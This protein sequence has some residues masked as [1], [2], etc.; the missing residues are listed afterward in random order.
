V[1]YG[2][3]KIGF[4]VLFLAVVNVLHAQFY[5]GHQ[6]T[7]GKNRVQYRNY[8]W[9]HYI[10]D[11]YKVYFSVGGDYTARYVGLNAS[12]I[13]TEM[14]YRLDYQLDGE[15]NFIVYND[16]LDFRQSNIGLVSG[17]DQYNIGGV[18]SISN[19]KVMI[20]HYG[21]HHHIDKQIR[22]AIAELLINEILVGNRFSDRLTNTA[23]I[24]YPEWY[25]KGLIAYYGNEFDAN[26]QQKIK[27]GLQ[28][29]KYRKLQWLTDED[30][31]LAGL[32]F[33]T[34]IAINYGEPALRD[35][36]YL[37]RITKNINNAFVFVT[38]VPFRYLIKEWAA[39]YKYRYEQDNAETEE[40]SAEAIDVRVKKK[41]LYQNLKISPDKQYIAWNTNEN[42]RVSIY[43]QNLKTGKKERIYKFGNSLPQ[44]VDVKYP[45]MQWFANSQMLTWIFEKEQIIKL[46]FY[47][48]E[49]K[50]LEFRNIAH[51]NRI[52]DYDFNSDGSYMVFSGIKNGKT[53]LF[54]L[55]L[56]SNSQTQLT[57]D[58]P[59]DLYPKFTSNDNIIFSSNRSSSSQNKIDDNYDVFR[60]PF[61]QFEPVSIVDS[62]GDQSQMIPLKKDEFLYLTDENGIRNRFYA[63]YD[64]TILFVDT[65]IHYRYF[66]SLQPMTNLN[67]GLLSHSSNAQKNILTQ[68]G[69]ENKRHTLTKEPLQLK[70]SDSFLETTEARAFFDVRRRFYNRQMEELKA[71][72]IRNDSLININYYIFEF[73]KNERNKKRWPDI[74]DDKLWVLRRRFYLTTFYTNYTV[75]QID[76]S[77]LNQSYQVYTGGAVFFNPGFN[78]LTKFGAADLFEDYKLTAGFRLAANF[79]GNEYLIS[80]ENVKNRLDKQLVFHRMGSEEFLED[81]FKRSYSYQTLGVI[82]YPFSQV[83]SV[84]LTGRVRID[85]IVYPAI[86]N[87]TLTQPD[88]YRFWGGW[89]AEYIYD[90]TE[91]L[92]LNLFK[93]TRAK[94][95]G[96]QYS[97]L[98]RNL[99]E[100]M[101]VLGADLRHYFQIHRQLIWANRFATS[102]SFGNAML[103]YYLGGVDNW[104]STGQGYFDQTI[105]VDK[106]KNWAFQTVA[107]NMRG[108]Q[109]NIRNGNSFAVFNS[110]L[111]WPVVRYI[112]NRPLNSDILDNF[113]IA[114]FFDMGSAW[115]GFDIT[116]KDNFYRYDYIENGPVSVRIDKRRDPVVAGYGFGF[117]TR[118][119]GY[120]MRFDWAW[121]IENK[122]I[123]DRVFYF[124]INLD[125]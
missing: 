111:R 47:N 62:R 124:S 83:S 48:P 56:I 55:E 86:N 109:Q 97:R 10:F 43:L 39:Y 105:P 9:Q 123:L 65:A 30:A 35:I 102:T 2:L 20:Y 112:F 110:E 34:F 54:L 46:F 61:D 29:G 76:F 98:E 64:S 81:E 38:G 19:N 92:G 122:Q 22:S 45:L 50:E 106:S 28:N 12:K 36:M 18:T 73:E 96:E 93:G 1:K 101:F 60:T 49:T 15:I 14:E 79:A 125:F 120:Y 80:I 59:D 44:K 25:I 67:S 57:N 23:L 27:D 17:N 24:A 107:T 26:A 31:A 13:L 72:Q 89:L 8:L 33:W 11:R 82:K 121:G 103:I 84:R 37:S 91:S 63:H 94:V 66:T 7:F 108:F 3:L 95:F 119:F 6:M 85:Q 21:D 77:Q 53:D 87:E 99:N 32:S 41:P 4:I 78:V 52:L 88:D 75:N 71:R 69:F 16:L 51:V 68:I 5:N 113:M 117:R 58:L 100:H 40:N 115:Y 90:N 74:E 116:N 118:L 114:G 70:Q 42:G 104:M